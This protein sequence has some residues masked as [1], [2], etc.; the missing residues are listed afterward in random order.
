MGLISTATDALA[1]RRWSFNVS[2]PD[3]LPYLVT[4][5]VWVRWSILV[6]CVIE[7]IYRPGFTQFQYIAYV[8]CLLLL[9]SANG[10][11]HYRVL[12]RRSVTQHWLLALSAM[13]VVLITSGM[14]VGGG[15]SN[16]FFYLVYYPALAGFAVLFS[17][18]RLCIAWA[19]TVAAIYV[20]VSLTVGEGLDF[21]AKDEKA[22]FA[23]I[24]V[25]YAIV[26]AVNLV[27]RF[28]RVRRQEA[29]ARERELQRERIALS[30]TIHDT[31]AQSA[32]MIGLGLETAMEL[33]DKSNQKLLD[34]LEATY[35]LLKSTMWELRHPVDIGLIFEGRDLGRVL[36]SHA[37]AFTSITSIPAEVVTTGG[38]PPLNSVTRS[39][40]FSI[41]HN[42]LTNAF[43][44]SRASKVAIELDFGESGLRMSLS[45]DGVGLPDDYA[46]RGHGF[47]NMRADA[48]R[49]GGRLE[50]ESGRSGRGT[51]ITCVIE[52]DSA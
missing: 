29:V 1:G 33:A 30:Q 15:Y 27:S 13:D 18:F 5:C 40:L 31:T 51:T 26:A 44:H 37:A 3:E 35:A 7:L 48:E 10:Y 19:T 17:S 22:L 42:A 14:I 16:Y 24:A 21:E 46:E 34:K 6:V 36:K 52:Y 8:S 12:S 47:R 11:V 20:A 28:E 50:V 45:D 4:I 43:R 2:D 25:F 9:V 38:E 49:M 23:R 39:M 32:Y 41:A